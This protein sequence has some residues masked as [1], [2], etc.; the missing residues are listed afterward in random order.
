VA[1]AL[2]I[3]ALRVDTALATPGLLLVPLVDA[4]IVFAARPAC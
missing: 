4:A 2:A 1:T 3:V